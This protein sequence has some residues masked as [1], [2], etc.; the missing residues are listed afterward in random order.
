MTSNQPNMMASRPL[1]VALCQ[2]NLPVGDIDG[3]LHRI[4][5][6]I[7][8]AR[9]CGADLTIFPEL[10]VTGYPP[11]DLLLN[12]RFADT[13]AA[14][15]RD[16]ARSVT[17]T[18]VVVGLPDR[19][20]DLYNAAAVLADGAVVAT[21]RKHFL[22][23][24]G[25]FDE[26][27]YFARGT[28]AL[29]ID[30]GGVGGV[31]GV[32]VGVTICE[33]LW[34]PGGPGQWAAVDGG[35]ELLVNLSG[36]PYH[37]GKGI[38]RERMLAQRAADY[39]CFVAFCNAVGGQDELV[40]DGHSLVLDPT[41]AVLARG[42]QFEEDLM[43][44]SIDMVGASRRRLHDPRWR[45][46]GHTAPERLQAVRV[47]VTGTAAAA[48]DTPVAASIPAILDQEAEV[49]RALTL[50]TS[51]YF[52]KNGFR[53]A[54]L[55]LSGGIDSALALT[56]AAD[57]LGPDAVTAVSMPSRFTADMN[58]EDGRELA[59]RLGV[60]LLEF[61]IADLAAAYDRALA[62]QFADT[63][64]GVAE[65]NVQA[66]I[67]GNLL[68]ALSNKFG[69][70]VLTTGNKSEMSVGYATLYGD[71]AGGFA[72][73]K[74]VLKTWVYR[75]SRWRNR[76]REVIPI[77]IIEKAPTA[78]LRAD[79]LDSDNLPPYDTL[80]AVLEAYVEEDR[81]P[82]EV[83]RLGFDAG[84]VERVV[85]MVDRAEYK[86]RQAP[87]GVRISVRAFGRDR[88]LPITNR[89]RPR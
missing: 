29:V 14:G 11:E 64:S 45:Q 34:Y 48:V 41:G 61:P 16:L 23:N 70:L 79:Q 35:A 39:G 52:R 58:Q 26:Q 72:V 20:H 54:V 50:G 85:A 22:P 4:S 69:W 62:S 27:R 60:E 57:A 81:S 86:R 17:D 83:T 77:R 13:A 51:D 65:E 76:D 36:S 6:L 2:C 32:R 47:S 84:L 33:D 31:G 8:R 7:D 46:P 73:L 67:R 53:H 42:R 87:P 9:G 68:M 28:S 10:S 74:D 75:L 15:V 25:V 56:V 59:Q 71:M 19:G 89:Y 12:P 49:Y 66:R 40:F 78:E 37:R 24:Y 88:R 80:D 43:V 38:E 44:V 1:R 55:G 30:L 82:H 3:N 5:G 21:Y 18:V 63:D